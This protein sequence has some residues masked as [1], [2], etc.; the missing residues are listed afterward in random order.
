MKFKRSI[1]CILM[2]FQFC[3][4]HSQ[5]LTHKQF[6]K[7][8]PD[9]LHQIAVSMWG[10]GIKRQIPCYWTDSLNERLGPEDG[11]NLGS[12]LIISQI[13]NWRNPTDPTDLID[14]AWYESLTADKILSDFQFS[15]AV[16]TDTNYNLSFNLR[17]IAPMYYKQASFGRE[18]VFV[19][20]ILFW[21]KMLDL[22]SILDQQ[23][24]DFL[25]CYAWWKRLEDS[26]E[27][28]Q[29]IWSKAAEL[30]TLNSSMD[31][32]SYKLG[33]YLY[34]ELKNILFQKFKEDALLLNTTKGKTNWAQFMS[35]HLFQIKTQIQN[36][37]NPDDPTDNR[38]TSYW[39]P[40]YKFDSMYFECGNTPQIVIAQKTHQEK[41]EKWI[42]YKI[43]LEEVRRF[44][45][46]AHF[47]MVE[48][49]WNQK[50]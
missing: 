37:Q 5:C 10:K 41:T 16:N 18:L 15:Y 2:V 50:I 25:R 13:Q 42:E 45:H 24:I 4:G 34:S 44:L 43:P 40:P 39:E 46:P 47:R 1:L 9:K 38:D 21:N 7:A 11:Y 12:Q 33:P 49:I 17:A 23:T 26:K 6:E 14:T 31:S 30:K 19:P 48:L 36:W 28:V 32:T 35:L 29:R 8:F 20:Q 3:F 27:P 22:N